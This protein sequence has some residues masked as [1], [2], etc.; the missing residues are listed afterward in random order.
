MERSM[1]E[2]ELD[3]VAERQARSP[4]RVFALLAVIQFLVVLD[5]S[6]VYIALPSIQT[7]LGFSQY[8]LAWVMDA[9]M[10]TFGGFMLI[11]GRAA[12]VLGRRR[13]LVVGLV[14]F[15]AASLACGIAAHSWQLVAARAAQGLGAA[16]VSPA[17]M[18]L[19]TDIF[20]EGPDRYK[21]MGMFGGI[22]GLAGA[23]GVLIGGVLAAIAWQL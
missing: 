16:I 17:A 9:Y 21:A 19:V 8:G 18:A 12:D 4:W 11:G 6:I 15:A 13:V 3:S 20:D 5:A 1:T 2:T 10:L 7:E 22:G 23:T 14:V